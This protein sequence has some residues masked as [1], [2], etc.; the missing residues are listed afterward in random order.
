MDAYLDIETTGLSPYTCDLSV[1]GI[2]LVDGDTA[3]MTQL[4]GEDI[5]AITVMETLQGAC[6][7]Y[8]YNGSRF[9]LPFIETQ[10][11]VDLRQSLRHR[12]LMYDCWKRGFYGGLKA[13][14]RL[15]GVPR[16]LPDMNG[17]EAI[18]LWHRYCADNDEQALTKLLDYNREDVL[19]LKTL[20][21]RLRV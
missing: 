13:V 16:K 1:V 10:L 7:L 15:L 14:E 4:V 9:D 6:S 3:E 18:R 2:A 20:R 8:T 21:T 12:D 17:L 11:G 5:T 19:N